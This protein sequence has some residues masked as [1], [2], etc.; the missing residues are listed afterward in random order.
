[1]FIHKRDLGGHLRQTANLCNCFRFDNLLVRLMVSHQESAT[2][3]LRNG[4]DTLFT[5]SRLS[6]EIWKEYNTQTLLRRVDGCV[7]PG[8]DKKVFGF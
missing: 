2:E 3:S 5:A 1:M 6:Q 7:R 8:L 4:F